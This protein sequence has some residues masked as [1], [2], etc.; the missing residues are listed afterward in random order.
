LIDYVDRDKDEHGV[1]P[2]CRVL[3]EAGAKIAPSTYYAAKSRSPSARAVADAVLDERISATHA[4]NFGVYGVRKMWRTLN[5]AD[6]ESSVARCTVQRRMRALGLSGAVR[7]RVK[8][9]TVPAEI[10]ARPGDLLERD[11]TA[12]AP[13]HRWVADI[14][15][16][17]TWHGFCYVAFVLDLFSRRIVG[18]RVSNSL[19]T[20]LALDAL[21]HALWQRERDQR[22][23]TGLIHHSDR[24]VQYLAIRY[25]ERLAV[26]GAIASVGSKGDS[27]D[28]AVAE[29][30]NGLYKTEVIRRRGPWRS[31]DDVEYATLEWV[32]W[33]NHHRLHSWCGDVPPAEYEDLYYR[34]TTDTATA[35]SA[36]PSLH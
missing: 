16:V 13:N 25:S 15:Y 29:S 2:I 31:L 20:D 26:A 36:Q 9:T 12:A 5:R 4:A 11:F 27:F 19:R 24:G 3:T 6:P 7:G 10:A 18:W 14:T 35:E 8:R 32:D 1:E 33:Y 17:A 23:V 22:D 30:L 21:E 28:N 34:Q